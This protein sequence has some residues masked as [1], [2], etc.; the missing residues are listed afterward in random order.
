[1]VRLARSHRP[2]GSLRVIER[3]EGRPLVKPKF[4]A[5]NQDITESETDCNELMKRGHSGSDWSVC[6]DNSDTVQ[7]DEEPSI[8]MLDAVAV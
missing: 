6:D 1:M 4:G 8:V 3:N 7:S 5:T 2:D